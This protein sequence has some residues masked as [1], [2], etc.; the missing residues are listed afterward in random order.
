MPSTDLY[1]FGSSEV[2]MKWREP[3]VTEGLNARSVGTMPP[4][5]YR[6]YILAPSAGVLQ[7]TLKADALRNDHVA[8]VEL[9]NGFTI[10]TRQT[11]GDL[12]VDLSALSGKTVVL[13]IYG[14]YTPGVDTTASIRAYELSPTDNFTGAPERPYLTILGTVVVPGAGVIPDANITHARRTAAWQSIAYEARPWAPLLHN[15][16][17]NQGKGGTIAGREC[18]FWELSPLSG[19]SHYEVDVGGG[20]SGGNALKLVADLAATNIAVLAQQLL[21]H[22]VTPGQRLRWR[23][24]YAVDQVPTVGTLFLNA[25]FA[26][27]EDGGG[28]TFASFLHQ[29]DLSTVTAGFL[30]VEGMLTVPANRTRLVSVTLQTGVSLRY[31][32]TTDALRVGEVQV[33]DPQAADG[34]PEDSRRYV[35][36]YLTGIGFRTLGAYPTYDAE[37]DARAYFEASSPGS[38]LTIARTDLDA[39]AQNQPGYRAMGRME[40]GYAGQSAN[41][42]EAH[43]KFRAWYNPAHSWASLFEAEPAVA[44]T[45]VPLRIMQRSNLA[46]SSGFAFVWGAKLDPGTPY[47]WLRTNGVTVAM[48]ALVAGGAATPALRIQTASADGADGVWSEFLSFLF[49][50]G[51]EPTASFVGRLNLGSAYSGVAGKGLVARVV[52]NATIGERSLLLSSLAPT[53]GINAN[54][55]ISDLG[56]HEQAVNAVWNGT[57]W[58]RTVIGV[59]AYKFSVGGSGRI[60]LMYYP[61]AGASPWNDNAWVGADVDAG[62]L[63]LTADGARVVVAAGTDPVL[64]KAA[65]LQFLTFTELA[66]LDATANNALYPKNTC[67]AWANVQTGGAS[68]INDSFG[69]SAIGFAGSVL[70]LTLQHPVLIAGRYASIQVTAQG[71]GGTPAVY[72]AVL[73]AGGTQIEVRATD[74]S[75]APINL[76]AVTQT[77]MIELKGGT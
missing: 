5:V 10:T 64:G 75:G 71:F 53:T 56:Q 49:N 28:F 25:I 23:I 4:G 3:Y 38:F 70:T 46:G 2:R 59:D 13:A 45:T 60:Q 35:D 68:A 48:R 42:A 16:R 33:W 1:L 31:A 20:V 36:A 65:R 77:L 6:G 37:Q 15:A 14:T 52:L 63:F 19:P 18:A 29:L 17:F 72:T 41:P 67:K 32:A 8:A 21:M 66:S 9:A 58:V 55:Y 34:D 61:A 50:S 24:K 26:E 47:N 51:G 39:T 43:P 44:G 30:E 69:I 62:K 27:N 57:Q 74:L 7:V 12:G 54:T 40:A 76:S 22:P 11:P 73:N